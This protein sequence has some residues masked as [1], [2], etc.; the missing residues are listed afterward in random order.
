MAQGNVLLNATQL[1]FLDGETEAIAA[2]SDAEIVRFVT[3]D[4]TNEADSD[5]G[6]EE[7]FKG[8]VVKRQQAP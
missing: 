8:A 2:M 4:G 7:D 6:E 1:T 5:V 3:T